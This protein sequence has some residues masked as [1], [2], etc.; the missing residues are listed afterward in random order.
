[1]FSLIT[2]R[3]YVFIA[4]C[5]SGALYLISILD[6]NRAIASFVRSQTS[7][8]S[9][10]GLGNAISSFIGEPIARAFSEPLWAIIAGVAWPLGLLWFLLFSFMLVFAF[11]APA[12]DSAADTIR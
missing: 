10:S 3:V 7:I 1:M 4:L 9:R 2:P 8:A 12:F 11:I 6:T 5:T